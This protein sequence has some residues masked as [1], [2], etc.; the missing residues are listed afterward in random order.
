MARLWPAVSYDR[1]GA[2]C[3]IPPR[4]GFITRNASDAEQVVVGVSTSWTG[5]TS[6]SLPTRAPRPWTS[7]T[8]RS[9]TPTWRPYGA[10]SSVPPPKAGRRSC[11][12][13]KLARAVDP[14]VAGFRDPEGILG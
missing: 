11:G 1:W 7:P 5:T 3:D 2:T 8:Q 6:A 14:S 12:E 4:D 9:T 10:T 13:I